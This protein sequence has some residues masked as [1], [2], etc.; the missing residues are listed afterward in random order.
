MLAFEGDEPI[1]EILTTLR[2]GQAGG[3]T[4]FRHLNAGIRSF[5]ED[6]ALVSRM[7]AAWKSNNA[8]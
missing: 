4:L 7:C 3:F 1:P 8:Y 6:P 5:G 2:A